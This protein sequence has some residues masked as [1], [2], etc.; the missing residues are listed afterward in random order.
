MYAESMRQ[1]NMGPLSFD[2]YIYRS[3]RGLVG[4]TIV[5]AD[6]IIDEEEIRLQQALEECRPHAD[7]YQPAPHVFPGMEEVVALT[8][9]QDDMVE[10]ED[11]NEGNNDARGKMKKRLLNRDV[12][13][14]EINLARSCWI[15]GVLMPYKVLIEKLQIIRCP[16]Q[17]LA[18]RRIREF[19]MQMELCWIGTRDTEP[20]YP[21]TPFQDWMKKMRAEGR[22]KLVEKVCKECRIFCSVLVHSAKGRL[23]PTWNHIQALELIDPTRLDSICY[24]TSLGCVA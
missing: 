4:A 6:V 8:P 21:Y 20:L 1:R 14:T 10:E 16:Q 3:R 5:S 11:F 17:H 9:T 13:I 24:T 7:G 15:A 19:Y 12:G 2:P 22:E 23:E 18:A